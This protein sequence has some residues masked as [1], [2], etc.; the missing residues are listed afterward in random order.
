MDLREYL[1]RKKIKQADFA[2]K[3]G[4]GRHHIEKIV[5][6]KNYASLRLAKLIQQATN[7]EVLA[8]DLTNPKYK[9]RIEE[10]LKNI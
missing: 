4:Y 10:N 7:G 1:F 5:H 9:K 8:E 2:K 3:I 6:Q